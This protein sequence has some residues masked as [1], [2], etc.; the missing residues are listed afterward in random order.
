MRKRTVFAALTALTLLG[1]GWTSPPGDSSEPDQAAPAETGLAQP[2]TAAPPVPEKPRQGTVFVTM[3]GTTGTERV[4]CSNIV[5]EFLVSPTGAYIEWTA[6]AMDREP[7]SGRINGNR[8]ST[9]TLS[10]ASGTV[11]PGQSQLVKVRGNYDGQDRRFWVP[12]RNEFG[13]VDLEFKC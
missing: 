6:Q 1:C 8:I 12:V 9:I 7:S 13:G 3:R 4:N 10:P 11:Q 2:T 5:T